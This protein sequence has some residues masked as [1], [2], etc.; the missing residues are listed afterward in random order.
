MFDDMVRLFKP[1]VAAIHGFVALECAGLTGG[2]YVA[3]LFE[4]LVIPLVLWGVCFIRYMWQLKTTGQD[5]QATNVARATFISRT[6]FVLFV[7]YPPI[8]SDAQ[9]SFMWPNH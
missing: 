7:V 5:A 9:P 4:V 3:W 1:L 8:V 6:F 2:F